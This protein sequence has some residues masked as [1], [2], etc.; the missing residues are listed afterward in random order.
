MEIWKDV[1][2]Y[3][4]LYQVS[5][6]GNV[7]RIAGSKSINSKEKTLTPIKLKKGYLRVALTKNNVG[8]RK[9]VHVLV[10][11]AF[12]GK[13]DFDKAQVNHINGI[14][15]DNTLTNLEWCTQSE[16]QK[17]MFYVLGVNH[18][19][20]C[21]DEERVLQIIEKLKQGQSSSI[22]ADEYKVKPH[23]IT[24]IAR[25]RSYKRIKRDILLKSFKNSKPQTM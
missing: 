9:L 16:N 2:G 20:R 15:T 21:L 10:L 13:P 4:G 3:E 19:K 1:L 5:N 7:K 8:K 11:E 18:S 14:K 17:H 25:G 23:V 24:D 22:I 12:V 6:L